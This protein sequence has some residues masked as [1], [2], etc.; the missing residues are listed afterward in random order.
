MQ[1]NPGGASTTEAPGKNAKTKGVRADFL[2]EKNP[3]FGQCVHK[4][5]QS[6]KRPERLGE[7]IVFLA[8]NRAGDPGGF[9]HGGI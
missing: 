6:A 7:I 1:P 5:A 8:A 3:E 4:I 2:P 9:W